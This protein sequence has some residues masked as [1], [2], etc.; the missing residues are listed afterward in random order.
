MLWRTLEIITFWLDTT[1]TF[2]FVSY[3]SISTRHPMY[4]ILARHAANPYLSGMVVDGSALFVFPKDTAQLSAINRKCVL[5][6]FSVDYV[7]VCLP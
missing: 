3:F 2:N 1:F 7:S 4:E 6:M 5:V